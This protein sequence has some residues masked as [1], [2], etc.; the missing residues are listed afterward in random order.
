[1][2]ELRPENS[3]SGAYFSPSRPLIPFDSGHPGPEVAALDKLM[4]SRPLFM[5][6]ERRLRCPQRVIHAQ[7]TRDV[8]IT[9]R[10]RPE[11]SRH[12]PQHGGGLSAPGHPLEW[13]KCDC[14][15]SQIETVAATIRQGSRIVS[16]VL[17]KIISIIS[18]SKT[19]FSLLVAEW[20]VVCEIRDMRCGKPLSR[21]TRGGPNSPCPDAAGISATGGKSARAVS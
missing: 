1:L 21:A 13:H 15:E 11:P 18:T 10:S 16:R 12:F 7:D 8:T 20:H 5:I 19:T 17:K 3:V 14:I 2:P 6:H 4:V 9:I